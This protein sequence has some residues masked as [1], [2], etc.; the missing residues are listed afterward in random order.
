MRG[1]SCIR[2]LAGA[3]KYAT[4]SALD[5]AQNEVNSEPEDDGGGSETDHTSHF[6]SGNIFVHRMSST[7]LCIWALD[8]CAEFGGEAEV[9]F[10]SALKI[11]QR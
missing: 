11:L 3:E 1:V 6:Y 2:H 4:N 9:H 10:S 5:G 8:K 7:Y